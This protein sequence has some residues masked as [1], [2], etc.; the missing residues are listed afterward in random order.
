[1]KKMAS[2]LVV[3]LLIVALLEP[4]CTNRD[5]SNVG[6]VSSDYLDY[7]NRDDEFSGGVKLIP[8]QTPSGA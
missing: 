4:G 1:M 5:Q 7:S 3:G 8:I 2:F 6:V